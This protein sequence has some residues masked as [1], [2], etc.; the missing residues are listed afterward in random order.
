MKTDSFVLRHIGPQKNE[1]KEMVKTI[2]VNSIDDLINKTI[3]TNIRL[4]NDLNLPKPFSEF[5]YITHIQKLSNKNKLF[6]NYIGLGYHP[7]ILPGVIQRNILENPGWYTSY[8]PYQ[9]EISQGRLEALLNY[10]TMVMELTGMELANASLLDEGTAAAEAMLMLFNSR[11]RAQKKENA[12]KFFVSNE[13]LPQ[14][15]D[16]LKT[17][18]YPLGIELVFGN[19]QNFEFTSVVFGVLIQYPSKNGQI[20]DYST[21]INKAKVVDAKIAVAADLLSLTILTPPGEWGADVV[22]GTTQRFGIPMGYGGPHAGY[23]ATKEAYKRAIPGRIIG[24]SHDKDG[25]RALRMALQTREQHIKREKATSNIC[26]AQVLL[27]VMAGMYGVYH[28]SKGLIYIASKIQKLT[29]TLNEGLK[30]L[31]IKQL[32][33]AFFDT[34]TI[35]V[36]NTVKLKEI[37]EKK[38]INFFYPS[39]NLVSISINETSNLEDIHEIISVLAEAEDK[40]YIGSNSIAE[41][42]IPK[43][44]TRQSPFMENDTFKKYHSE[45]EMMRYIKRLE[46]KDLSLTHSMIS[47]GSCTMKLNAAT[48]ML[49]LSW[50]NWGNMHPFVP[51]EQ[52]Q[53]YQE[54]ITDLETY[55]NEITGFAATSLQPNS[56]AQ[57]EYAGLTVIKAFHE[58]KGNKHRNICLIPSS[59]H[60]TNPA[61]AVMAGFK[62]VVTKSTE[63]GN[64]DVDDLREKAELYK[65]SLGAL[66]VTYPSTHGVFESS[67]KEIT[68]IIHEFGG[69]VYM[70]G[71]NMNAQVGLTNPASI[72]ADVCHL[73]LHKTFAI[74]H[75]GGGPG[76]GPICV[77]KH[78]VPFLPSNPIIPTGGEKATTAIS[79]APWGSALVLLISYSYIRMLGANG[80]KQ[81]TKYAILNANYIKA[82]LEKHYKILYTG[83]NGFA[84][85]EMIV[86]FREFKEKGADV[87]DVSKRLMDFGYHAPTVS[88]PVHG[89]LMIEPTESENKNELDRFCDAL[90]AIKSEINEMKSGDT[91]SVLK[92]APH[93]QEMLTSNEWNYPYTRQKAAFPLPYLKENKFWPSVRRIDDAFGDRNLVCSCN[94]IEDYL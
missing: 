64:I 82:R 84:A 4:T 65:D 63:K 86:D 76:V 73:N 21:F 30:Q 25:N 44:L 71:A 9:A 34:L 92:N 42:S 5:E 68:K 88:F 40:K 55:L 66:M 72:G 8:T 19:H 39:P 53:G 26:T 62:V 23:F 28:G 2:G 15:I 35:E 50:P 90:I 59:A 47:L 31:N 24:V 80:L 48:E 29:T 46:L 41:N 83:E 14:T 20:Y 94:P 33:T 85:H 37:A 27:A 79:S 12:T 49:P 81:S 16:V 52:A 91:N 54:V 18:A 36:S 17:R 70:D 56:G 89:T 13:V 1:V 43:N 77:A 45:T 61:S 38:E 75:G 87:T 58:S 51:I 7:T 11:T 3:P 60:G 57:G 78:L 67:I 32:N 10:Q 93:T 22:I 69:Q 6:K 74:P